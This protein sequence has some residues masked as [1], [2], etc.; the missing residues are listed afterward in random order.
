MRNAT[1]IILYLVFLVAFFCGCSTNP[2]S[3]KSIQAFQQLDFDSTTIN[4]IPEDYK[5]E[6]I[7]FYNLFSPVEF[8]YLIEEKSAYYN[9]LL[10][11]PINNITRYNSSDKYAI[12]IGVYGADLSYLWMF[13]QAQQ[14]L[15]YRSAI[16]RLT[17]RLD[18]PREFVDF[19]YETAELHSQDFDTLVIVAKKSYNTADNFLKQIGRPQSAAL[20]LFGGWIETLYIATNMYE[21]PDAALL[22]RIAIQRYSLNSLYSLLLTFQEN[23]EIKEYLLLLKKLKKVYDQQDLVIPNESLVIDTVAKHIKMRDNA[24]QVLSM[25]QFKEIQMLTNQ[26]RNHIIQ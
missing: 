14:A 11:N 18:V 2:D 26:I 22:N 8:T 6:E 5:E 15:S 19:T 21:K 16:Q 7:I 1:I 23:L 3:K 20:I 9:S 25:D 17:D 24:I 12:N 13:D 10:I 4:F